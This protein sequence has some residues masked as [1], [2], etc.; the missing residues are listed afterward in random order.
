[1]GI[2]QYPICGVSN[3]KIFRSNF[4]KKRKVPPLRNF[5]KKISCRNPTNLVLTDPSRLV[6][7]RNTKFKF[8]RP[9]FQE[10]L[11]RNPGF[12]LEFRLPRF[13]AHTPGPYRLS[14][15]R[16][17]LTTPGP[18]SLVVGTGIW[19]AWH[20]NEAPKQFR[21]RGTFARKP[22]YVDDLRLI[23]LGRTVYQDDPKLWPHLGHGP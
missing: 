2:R 17:T 18:W 23:P 22:V 5:P 14:G 4:G 9:L 10:I 15:R 16:Q 20:R 3:K 6:G 13:P 21:S 1:M 7:S 11:A 8:V 12:R 19:F